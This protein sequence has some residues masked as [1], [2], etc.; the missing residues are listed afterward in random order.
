MT[1]NDFIDYTKQ[2]IKEYLPQEYQDAEVNIDTIQKTNEKYTGMI[3]RPE[4]MESAPVINM[5]ALYRSYLETDDL[6]ATIEYISE[7]MQT[8]V[9]P[10][11]SADMMK[12]Y[13]QMREKLFIRLSP[14]EGSEAVM[15]GSP[16]RVEEDLL[17]TY[18]IMIPGDDGFMSARITN[19]ILSGFGVETK[20]L[21]EDAVA[22]TPNLLPA[23]VQSMMAAL[24]G[25]EEDDPKMIVVTNEQGIFGA[26]A[27]FCGG[28]M[29]QVGD[30]LH[31]NYYLLPSSVHEWIAVPDDGTHMRSELEDMV[32]AA[33]QTV[34]DPADKLSDNVFHYD[35]RERMFE[36]ADKHEVRIA[37]KAAEKT[38]ERGSLLGRLN[39]KKEQVAVGSPAGKD[40]HR[41]PGLAI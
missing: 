1:F 2:H 19:E 8:A 31:G 28:V 18:H 38:V 27:L 39:N 14:L 10:E 35:V 7:M 26:G 12:D 6:D 23:K 32:K 13:D 4:G 40:V 25:V 5:D 24:T 29:D 15:E 20:Q 16:H 21:H 30:K 34:V 9:P 37:A 17:M 41:Q 33:N 3:V 22:N 11:V 36:R